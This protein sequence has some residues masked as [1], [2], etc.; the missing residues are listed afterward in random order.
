MDRDDAINRLRAVEPQ[1]RA[2]GVGALYLYG[3]YAR[4]D[5]KADSDIDIIVDF[6]PDR[7]AGLT[8]YLEPYHLI[9][10][11]FPGIRIGYSTRDSLVPEYRSAIEKYAIRIF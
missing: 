11:C 3:S 5:A 4:N 10:D 2:K 9:E 1:I 7:G 8:A 6:E